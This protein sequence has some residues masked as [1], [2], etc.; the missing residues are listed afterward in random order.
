MILHYDEAVKWQDMLKGVKRYLI[1]LPDHERNISVVNHYLTE[2]ARSHPQLSISLVIPE[3][4]SG[5][6]DNNSHFS[7][8][9]TFPEVRSWKQ[10]PINEETVSHIPRIFDVT[11]D[12]NLSPNVLSHYISATR[13]NRLTAGFYNNMSGELFVHTVVIRSESEYEK[14]VKSLLQIGGLLESSGS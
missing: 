13:G 4:Y 3:K 11:L 10:F 6:F 1:N 14:G 8:V 7:Q 5:L 9:F 12:L 2:I